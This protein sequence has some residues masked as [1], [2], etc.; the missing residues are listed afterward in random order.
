MQLFLTS[1]SIFASHLC[2]R[3]DRLSKNS[4]ARDQKGGEMG[5]KPWEIS[6]SK[7]LGALP[8]NPFKIRGAFKVSFLQGPR[9][10]RKQV[11]HSL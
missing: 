7:S 10:T 9:W 2:L 6:P 5:L 1:H 3:E 11:K 4:K 8:G